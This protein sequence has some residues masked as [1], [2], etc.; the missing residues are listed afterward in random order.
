MKMKEKKG[1][2]K[3]FV[4]S[5]CMYITTN[6]LFNFFFSMS[7]FTERTYV[8]ALGIPLMYKLNDML[9]YTLDSNL[10]RDSHVKRED[11]LIIL[12][13]PFYILE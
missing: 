10:M 3:S 12:I 9:M 1:I 6:Y 11:Y 8:F 5:E 2:Y 7:E 4:V 13:L